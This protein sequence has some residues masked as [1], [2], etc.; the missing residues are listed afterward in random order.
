[1]LS[2][3]LILTLQTYP[4]L[5]SYAM[6]G[7]SADKMHV[8][9]YPQTLDGGEHLVGASKGSVGNDQ[10]QKDFTNFQESMV[11]T[12]LQDSTRGKWKK[13]QARIYQFS[14]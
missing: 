1:M 10:S 7:L 11:L 9:L 5:Y 4:T 3:S 12:T 14:F 2:G 8:L 13:A 6:D